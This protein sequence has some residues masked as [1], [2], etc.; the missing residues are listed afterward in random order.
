[1]ANA[2][3]LALESVFRAARQKTNGK[4]IWDK[5]EPLYACESK[6]VTI[7]CSVISLMT[8]SLFGKD[9]GGAAGSPNHYRLHFNS[10]LLI[11]TRMCI[12]AGLFDEIRCCYTR[13][14]CVINRAHFSIKYFRVKSLI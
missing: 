10:I 1:M 2:E 7:R 9:G 5:Q 4:T 11:R 6:T 12:Q 8:S 13:D 3:R 14:K